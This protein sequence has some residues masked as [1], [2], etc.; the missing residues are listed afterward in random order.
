MET[1]GSKLV[2]LAW[3]LDIDFVIFRW[4]LWQPGEQQMAVVN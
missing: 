4:D 3:K 1:L 2:D